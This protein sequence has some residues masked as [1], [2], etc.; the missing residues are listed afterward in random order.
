M[1]IQ[2]F[3]SLKYISLIVLTH[4][5][6]S[7]WWV[8]LMLS[9]L[10]NGC[11]G[12]I[13]TI[14]REQ[15]ARDIDNL[16]LLQPVVNFELVG[17]RNSILD[18]AR[19]ADAREILSRLLPPYLRIFGNV[20]MVTPEKIDAFHLEVRRLFTW[21]DAGG[22]S[23]RSAGGPRYSDSLAEILA[24]SA[25][26]S[27]SGGRF[28]AVCY[29]KYSALTEEARALRACGG[30]G[31][32]SPVFFLPILWNGSFT[33]ST[34]ADPHDRLKSGLYFALLDQDNRVV[35]YYSRARLFDENPTWEPTIEKKVRLVVTK[36]N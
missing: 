34:P 6:K 17:A 14:P 35:L 29:Y 5:R 18:T 21:L 3:F 19:S 12:T 13:K 8:V 15:L 28:L 20:R 7:R 26:G 33:L 31:C 22:E 25:S 16:I 23:A 27:D 30:G 32:L 11:A 36:L 24:A 10:L 1:V 2:N 4:D 9:L